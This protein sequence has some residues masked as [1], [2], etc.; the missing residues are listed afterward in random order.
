[1]LLEAESSAGIVVAGDSKVS[2]AAVKTSRIMLG[3][4]IYSGREQ[5]VHSTLLS[6]M[7]RDV[8][9]LIIRSDKLLMTYAIVE[10]EKRERERYNDVSYSLKLLAKL[11]LEFRE[12]TNNE[13]AC[14]QDLVMP[15]NY[16]NVVHC[17]KILSGYDGIRH[18]KYPSR[19]I[20]TGLALRTLSII[21]KLEHLKTGSFK[22][23]EKM[24][25][26]EELYKSDYSFLANNARNVYYKKKA[27][28]PEELPLEKDIKS[29]RDFCI[30]EIKKICKNTEQLSQAEY[31]Y[32]SKLVYVR[33]MTFNARR[34][35]EP[36]KITLNDWK[37]AEE[38][39]W[40]RE[41]D[42][43]RL[44]DPVEKM[45]AKKNKLC[46]IE[47]KKKKRFDLD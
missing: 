24:R 12:I 8:R 39:R 11:L 33:L 32:L 23:V 37:M 15:E 18:I 6:T 16:D 28:I 41:S 30:H 31:T 26:F 27:N 19:I 22:M 25:C 42:L 38:D 3:T 13:N 5:M 34:G 20:Q 2:S 7:K 9:H 10:I 45:L 21:V 40:K 36:G 43:E 46:Y 1:M 14:S 44:T 4:D 35:G 47:G 29:L 17:I